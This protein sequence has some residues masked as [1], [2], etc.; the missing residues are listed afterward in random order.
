MTR[1]QPTELER[2]LPWQGQRLLR[3]DFR[4]AQAYDARLRAWH[5]RSV[6]ETAGVVFG[7]NVTVLAKQVKVTF[8]LAYDRSGSEAFL[9]DDRTV[10]VPTSPDPA[11][12]LVVLNPD[13]T[14]W[15]EDCFDAMT[16]VVLAR[17]RLRDGVLTKDADCAA[18][19]VRPL[20]RPRMAEGE[21]V[22][23]NTPWEI[24]SADFPNADGVF[25]SL[26][27]QTR[28]D[29]SAAGFTETPHYF[30]NL[31][32]QDWSASGANRAEFAP[33]Y[34]AHIAEAACDGF[35][36]RLLLK[37][38]G[39]RV[40]GAV[41]PIARVQ[42]VSIANRVMTVE[43][44]NAS[45]FRKGDRVALVRPR[46]DRAASLTEDEDGTLLLPALAAFP[47][48]THV[49]LGNLPRQSTILSVDANLLTV[50]IVAGG[51][52]V[53]PANVIGRIRA[54]DHSATV[55]KVGSTS[56]SGT[57][58]DRTWADAA[59]GDSYRVT[60]RKRTTRVAA[61][62][63]TDDQGVTITLAP[64]SGALHDWIVVVLPGGVLS[65]P[66]VIDAM[67]GPQVHVKN[68]PAGLGKGS[69][70]YVLDQPLT[71]T[72]VSTQPGTVAVVVK[73]PQLF[74]TGDVV[75]VAEHSSA[76]GVVLGVEGN[77]VSV[78]A[79]G[80]LTAT[81]GQDHLV[82]ANW[83]GATTVQIAFFGSYFAV[84]R[85]ALFRAGNVFLKWNP[86]VPP[87]S[88]D[89]VE[90]T[91]EELGR[92]Q[93][94]YPWGFVSAAPFAAAGDDVLL[95]GEFPAVVLVNSV[96][97]DGRV[98]VT[99]P[100]LQPG[101]WVAPLGGN[102]GEFTVA[103][104]T[105]VTASGA[106]FVITLS[107]LV[108]NILPGAELGV[109]NFRDIAQIA[110]AGPGSP[111]NAIALNPTLEVRPMG[112]FVARWTAPQPDAPL[113]YADNSNPAV[114]DSIAGRKLT[115]HDVG[116]GIIP[117][118]VIDG[119]L[120]GLAGFSEVQP[121]LRL[122]ADSFVAVNEQ[123]TIGGPNQFETQ[124]TLLTRVKSVDDS[125]HVELTLTTPAQNYV[126]RPERV[127]VLS[128]YNE[129]FPEAFAT[130]AQKQ[131]LYVSWVACQEEPRLDY[132]RDDPP[133][134]PCKAV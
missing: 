100:A 49:A 88:P 91:L 131:G 28:V 22:H 122:K 41:S 66:L 7:L 62:P 16:G 56:A 63:V 46:G 76:I 98:H 11:S 40:S 117:A 34:F 45:E 26:G 71:I 73:E 116:D 25:E 107:S 132:P 23:G 102:S 37:D 68:A 18:R 51:A 64:D 60:S 78:R 29:T 112:D 83:K 65:A 89:P 130:F 53:A 67:N 15:P 54:S 114:V 30:A 95:A 96:D 10:L 47:S 32:A 127:S 8:G 43:L 94:V 36:F 108:D 134:N 111:E 57:V 52:T 6:H 121:T 70:V 21:T 61:D 97:P 87:N 110:D 81:A 124:L 50:L 104:V 129:R 58:L 105:S 118:P 126:L 48:G 99:G 35:T 13:L 3:R 115:L 33:A 1:P 75:T 5:N 80:G 4:D 86:P 125:N 93:Q 69:R 14:L 103:E 39:K 12:Y 101:D 109:V 17:V 106:E 24:W 82:A 55:A 59:V 133:Q 31:Q 44:D 85:P 20:A 119:G 79:E 9:A 38:I 42:N 128:A 77:E 72:G 123:L 92:V 84:A 90:P 120:L 19:R 27:V 74:A 2:L 113:F